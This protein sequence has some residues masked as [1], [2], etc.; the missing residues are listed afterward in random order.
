MFVLEA[1]GRLGTFK[2]VLSRYINLDQSHL[3]GTYFRV[4]ATGLSDGNNCLPRTLEKTLPRRR[5]PQRHAFTL[6]TFYPIILLKTLPAAALTV[7]SA[8]DLHIQQKPA[9]SNFC[10]EKMSR[11]YGSNWISPAS[12]DMSFTRFPELPPELRRQVW[13]EACSVPRTIDL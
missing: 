7:N 1:A 9:T 4:H 12:K 6:S 10:Q 11:E 8:L 5:R 3:P 2:W 13:Q